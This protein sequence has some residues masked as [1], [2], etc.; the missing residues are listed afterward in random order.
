MNFFF[1]KENACSPFGYVDV[2]QLYHP[3][4]RV[5]DVFSFGSLVLGLIGKRNCTVHEE[6]FYISE[7]AM[8]VYKPNDCFV[9]ESLM[10]DPGFDVRDGPV[11][12]K[13][14]ML[15]IDKKDEMR[16]T[17]ARVVK[18][19]EGL[20]AVK[21]HGMRLGSPYLCSLEDEFQSAVQLRN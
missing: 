7:W 4:G 10:Q 3:D 14:A 12:T 9:H 20:F 13:L 21:K 11:I 5:R 6:E 8:E 17:M 1:P 16:P 15:C 19:L 18:C 2:A